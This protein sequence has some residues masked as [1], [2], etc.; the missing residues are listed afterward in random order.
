MGVEASEQEIQKAIIGLC[1]KTGP[2]RLGKMHPILKADTYFRAL[3][4]PR[5]AKR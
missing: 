1:Q 4:D 5:R 2:M 3:A